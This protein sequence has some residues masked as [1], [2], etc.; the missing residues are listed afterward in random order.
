VPVCQVEGLAE[1]HAL[2]QALL[3]Q[4]LP[5]QPIRPRAV[6]IGDV[7]ATQDQ[8]SVEV[9]VVDVL[10]HDERRR[11]AQHVALDAGIVDVVAPEGDGIALGEVLRP[12]PPQRAL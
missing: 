10:Q 9:E 11:Q 8:Q 3:G 1:R 7:G 5:L 12:P 4:H 6:D 2:L